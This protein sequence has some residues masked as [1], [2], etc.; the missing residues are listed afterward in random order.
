[1]AMLI[2]V[3]LISSGSGQEENKEGDLT[4]I[5][6]GFEND[7]G[8]AMVALS[9]SEED[10]DTRGQAFQSNQLQIKKN[11]AL[12]TIQNLPFGEYAI[13]VYHDEDD[14]GEMDT[15][16]LGIPSEDYGFSNDA[17]GSFGPASW[18]DAKFLFNSPQDT[19]HIKV[20]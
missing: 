10:Y 7:D 18:E 3:V 9:N 15:N 20:D 17:T 1:M 2:A 13:K 4:I 19:V 12:W 6:K 14:D 5:L 16:F 11:E 8:K